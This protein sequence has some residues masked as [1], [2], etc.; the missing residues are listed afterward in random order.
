V[1]SNETLRRQGER[2]TVLAREA[3][4]WPTVARTLV[5]GYA[6]YATKRPGP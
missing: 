2:A 3:F 1:A 6:R 4:S 5:D